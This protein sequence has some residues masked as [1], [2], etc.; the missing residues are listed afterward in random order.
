MRFDVALRER[1]FLSV[2][3]LVSDTVGHPARSLGTTQMVIKV[4]RHAPRP[5]AL[6]LALAQTVWL[7][8][9]VEQV[10]LLTE[11]LQRDEVLNTLRPRHRTVLV[12][13]QDQH[14]RL[15]LIGKVDRRVLSIAQRVFPRRATNARLRLLVL[16]LTRH[17]TVVTNAAIRREHVTDRRATLDGLKDVRARHQECRLV[18]A[19]TVTSSANRILVDEALRD[20]VLHAG[21]DALHA[22]RTGV[23]DFVDDVGHKPQIA[24]ADVVGRVG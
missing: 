17:A 14:R 1:Q 24:V 9:I 16:E 10:G 6:V 12:V 3:F 8:V 4:F 5:V 7:A 19:P 23:A 22:R 18:A 2:A 13:M 15:H 21:D 20:Q 11:A